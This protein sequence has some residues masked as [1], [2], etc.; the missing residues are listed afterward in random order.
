MRPDPFQQL[1]AASTVQLATDF[2]NQL[3]AAHQQGRLLAQQEQQQQLHHMLLLRQQ[4]QHHFQQQMTSAAQEQVSIS[5]RCPMAAASLAY[6]FDQSVLSTPTLSPRR[7][8]QQM[9]AQHSNMLSMGLQAQMEQL[10]IH[11]VLLVA[12]DRAQDFCVSTS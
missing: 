5:I 3:L 6:D 1:P 10:H 11:Q 8:Q 7:W 9:A 4:E 2:Q 12:H